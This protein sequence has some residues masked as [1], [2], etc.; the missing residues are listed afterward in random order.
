MVDVGILLRVLSEV[1]H[2][3]FRPI[4]GQVIEVSARYVILEDI[5]KS[6]RSIGG[7]KLH[8]EFPQNLIIRSRRSAT[9]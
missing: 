2:S 4:D 5:K 7:G 1:L 6:K 8:Q 3:A 9:N